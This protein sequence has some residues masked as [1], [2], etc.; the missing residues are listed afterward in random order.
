MDF[1]G[2][3]KNLIPYLPEYAGLDNYNQAL[4]HAK[5][6]IISEQHHNETLKAFGDI[7]KS[8]DNQISDIRKELQVS[9]LENSNQ[10]KSSN[11]R[12]NI[13]LVISIISAIGSI[14]AFLIALFK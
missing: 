9:N 7:K 6:E 1:N 10:N 5:A 4:R 3:D 12:S 14:G 11:K 2:I 13:S 8:L